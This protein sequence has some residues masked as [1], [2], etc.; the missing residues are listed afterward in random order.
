MPAYPGGPEGGESRPNE[1][2]VRRSGNRR[3]VRT[4]RYQGAVLTLNAWTPFPGYTPALG[5]A[6]GPAVSGASGSAN[7]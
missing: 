1:A 6:Y 7:A 3:L 5:T 2:A 4:A